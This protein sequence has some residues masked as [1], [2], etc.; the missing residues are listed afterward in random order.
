[1]DLMH[2][3]DPVMSAP[4]LY[5]LLAGLSSLDGVVPVVP[6]EAAV[7]TAG[8]LARTG[9]ASLVLVVVATAAG[10]FIGDHLAYGLSRSA[11]SPRLLG[12]SPRFRRAVTEAGRQLEHRAGPLIVASRFLPGGRVTMN[13]AAGT[14]GV[15]LS[16]FSPASAIAAL[17]WAAYIAGLGVLGG[18]AFAERPLLGVAVGL[19]ASLLVGSIVELTRRRLTAR[20][21]RHAGKPAG[22]GKRELRASVAT[23]TVAAVL[24]APGAA[25]AGPVGR[26]PEHAAVASSA[27]TR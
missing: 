24:A 21:H 7:L 16:R 2:L 13:V 11:S 17:A 10:V 6:S 26:I 3:I 22:A 25:V 1:M 8:V 27:V 4:L 15:P 12:R 23:M 18:T 20:P 5:P 19:G 14:A 9:S